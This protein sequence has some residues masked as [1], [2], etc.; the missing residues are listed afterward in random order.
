MKAKKS[1][2]VNSFY[3]QVFNPQILKY[4]TKVNALALEERLINEVMAEVTQQEYQDILNKQTKS[5]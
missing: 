4:S 3:Q 5:I 2:K 1:N